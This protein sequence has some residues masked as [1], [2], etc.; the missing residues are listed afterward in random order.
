MMAQPVKLILKEK[1]KRFPLF[2][3]FALVSAFIFEETPRFIRVSIFKNPND[4][5]LWDLGTGWY[6]FFLIWYGAIFS[7]AY[8]IFINKKLKYAVIFGIIF[9][10]LAETF[11]FRKMDN[12][13]S[14]ILF[15]IL[16][17]GMFYLP[18]RTHKLLHSA[19]F[20]NSLKI[21]H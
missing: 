8:F 5:H 13:F 3:F 19:K 16:Y 2:L 15:I 17:G 4:A 6:L 10:L 18:F 7:I 1:L 14:F 11:Y 12:I 21:R 9:G 20:Q